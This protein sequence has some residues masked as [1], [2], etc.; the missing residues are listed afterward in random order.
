ML[1]NDASKHE[2]LNRLF[3][4]YFALTHSWKP[5]PNGIME[6]TECCT[7]DSNL[8]KIVEDNMEKAQALIDI[9]SKMFS[10]F[11]EHTKPLFITKDN[12]EEDKKIIEQLH[13]DYDFEHTIKENKDKEDKKDV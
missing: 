9:R 12:P 3:M 2:Y 1:I 6:M 8:M 5:T 4:L 10:D 7:F 13:K 11:W